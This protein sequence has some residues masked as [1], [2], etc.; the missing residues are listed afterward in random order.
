MIKKWNKWELQIFIMM[1][2]AAF[3]LF[4]L[5]GDDNEKDISKL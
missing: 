1:E 2:Y 3:F 4:K 5:K